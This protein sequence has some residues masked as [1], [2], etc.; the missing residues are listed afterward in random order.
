M[1][2]IKNFSISSVLHSD[3]F[4]I[5]KSPDFL[6]QFVSLY[7]N[8]SSSK[9]FINHEQI[10]SGELC[11]VTPKHITLSVNKKGELICISDEKIIPSINS[12]GELIFTITQ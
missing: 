6:E 10:N 2:E 9:I 12:N 5:S 11:V 4:I 3:G 1:S 7:L 8:L